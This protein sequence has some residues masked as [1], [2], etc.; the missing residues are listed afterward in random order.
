[1]TDEIIKVTMINIFLNFDLTYVI[2]NTFNIQNPKSEVVV[3]QLKLNSQTLPEF[4]KDKK[5]FSEQV[6]LHGIGFNSDLIKVHV[7]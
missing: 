3:S 6:Y 7:L 5:Q 4:D 1:M 2:Q